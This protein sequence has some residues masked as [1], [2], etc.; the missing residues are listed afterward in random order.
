[1]SVVIDNYFCALSVREE[2][3]Y[4]DIWSELIQK[5]SSGQ[6]V[7]LHDVQYFNWSTDT[8]FDYTK[9][10]RC[11]TNATCFQRW[12]KILAATNIKVVTRFWEFW[13]DG[14]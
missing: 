14:W 3:A 8:D 4:K 6:K 5:T 11:L 7:S 10:M 2:G 13:Q 1:M 12:N 9:E